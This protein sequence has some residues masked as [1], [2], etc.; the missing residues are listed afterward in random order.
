ME[1]KIIQ[2]NVKIG[3]LKANKRDFFTSL[4]RQVA[5]LQALIDAAF[6]NKNIH[7]HNDKSPIPFLTH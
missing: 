3:F 1:N 4:Y 7:H 2:K 5:L 6:A